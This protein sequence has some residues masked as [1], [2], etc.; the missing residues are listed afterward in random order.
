M[1]HKDNIENG[2]DGD[3]VRAALARVA[4]LND[5]IEYLELAAEELIEDFARALEG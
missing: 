3:E 5:A 1:L 2:V 4:E